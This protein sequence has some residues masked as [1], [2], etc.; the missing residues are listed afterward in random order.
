MPL[1]PVRPGLVTQISDAEDGTRLL[2]SRCRAC[3]EVSL[4]TSAVCLNCGGDALDSTTLHP[5]GT[6]WTYTIVRYRPPGD[7]RGPEPFQ[8]FALGLV[9]LPDGIRVMAP[10]AGDPDSFAIGQPLKIV[11]MTLS[12]PG[13]GS[14]AFAFAH[15]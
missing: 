15:A 1:S 4:G 13:D 2:G 11:R 10:L 7:Y 12:G 8:P 5:E 6:L 9:E 3:S 14:L